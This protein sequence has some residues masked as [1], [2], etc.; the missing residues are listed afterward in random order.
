MTQFFFRLSSR[1]PLV[2]FL[3]DLQWCDQT[4]LDLL[5]YLT[6]N[7]LGA[8]KIA[9]LC[10]CRN[11]QA[12]NENPTL[13]KVIAEFSTAESRNNIIQLEKFDLL[14]TRKIIQKALGPG[15]ASD[16]FCDLLYRKSGGNPF[17]MTEILSLLLERGSAGTDSQTPWASI[18]SSEL[19][20]PNTVE[21]VVRKRLG[22]SGKR[23][24]RGT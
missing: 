3:D 14:Q 9:I 6:T 15:N 24:D 13:Q 8:R 21:G 12:E 5:H 16:A 11:D 17:F 23:I 4:S 19:E 22:S 7:G 18:S 10:A 1:S 2:L 20:V